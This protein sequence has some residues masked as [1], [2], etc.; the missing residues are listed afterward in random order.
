LRRRAAVVAALAIGVAGCGSRERV[1]VDERRGE[2][3]GIHFGDTSTRVRAV[4]GREKGREGFVPT[5][6]RGRYTGPRA[7]PVGA[8]TPET[9]DYETDAY[10]VSPGFGVL[11][12]TT[13]AG[14][15]TTRAGVSIGDDLDAVRS[16]YQRVICRET[17]GGEA[18]SYRWC[19]AR[20]GHVA[21]FFGGDPIS[22]ITLTRLR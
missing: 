11:S 8:R 17:P 19:R 5:E 7:I 16:R 20:V 13:V 22:S 3:A 10:L 4:R 21:V 12:M 6:A 15:A 18:G 9:L 14:G 1:V 2:V